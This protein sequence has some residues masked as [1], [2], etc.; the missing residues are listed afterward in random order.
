VVTVGGADLWSPKVLRAGM[1]A[2]FAGRISRMERPDDLLGGTSTTVA[3]VVSGGSPPG[4]I[5]RDGSVTLLV[6]SEAHGLP[7]GVVEHCDRAM[8][9]PMSGGFE[10]L[11]A[12]IA[13]SIAMYLLAPGAPPKQKDGTHE[14]QPE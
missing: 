6:G 7:R 10:S 2:H 14:P 12:A 13:G 5:P 9:I 4:T 1:G 8:T 11:N 3:T